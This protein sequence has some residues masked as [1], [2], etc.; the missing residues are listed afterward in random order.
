M[1]TDERISS[2]SVFLIPLPEWLFLHIV[3]NC[4]RSDFFFGLWSEKKTMVFNRNLSPFPLLLRE[5]RDFFSC[6]H[7]SSNV[8][9]FISRRL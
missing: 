7:Y 8:N 2:L 5:N 3:E 1:M 9:V 4:I 6:A